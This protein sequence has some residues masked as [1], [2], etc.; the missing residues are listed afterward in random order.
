M[1][2]KCEENRFEVSRVAA[3]H[4]TRALARPRRTRKQLLLLRMTA[5]I[6][7]TVGSELSFARS[8]D[9]WASVASSFRVKQ[10]Q[11]TSFTFFQTSFPCV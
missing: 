10:K 6:D 3:T 8:C 5:T 2:H 4:E 9:Y 7:V 1:L 11:D